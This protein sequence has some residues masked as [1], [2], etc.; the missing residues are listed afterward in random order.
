MEGVACAKY[1]IVLS[2]S[3][4]SVSLRFSLSLF[5]G[6]LFSLS[7]GGTAPVEGGGDD[8]ADDSGEKE[9]H[10]PGGAMMRDAEVGCRLA[11]H[12]RR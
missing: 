7:F 2:L 9:S 11:M 6:P 8:E 3:F 10:I 5:S 4:V 1:E 12:S